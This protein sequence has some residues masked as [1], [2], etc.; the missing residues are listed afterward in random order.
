MAPAAILTSEYEQLWLKS[1]KDDSGYGL[2]EHQENIWLVI[3]P[4]VFFNQR[5]RLLNGRLVMGRIE[6]SSE[7]T[8]LPLALP[9][10]ENMGVSRLH[11]AIMPMEHGVVVEDVGSTNGSRINGLPLI[12]GRTYNLNHGDLLE[13][14]R[15][16]L[17]IHFVTM[18]LFLKAAREVVVRRFTPEVQELLVGL[19]APTEALIVLLNRLAEKPLEQLQVVAAFREQGEPIT[20]D[21]L[22]ERINKV[23][24]T[25]GG[26]GVLPANEGEMTWTFNATKIISDP[27]AT[28]LL[29]DSPITPQALRETA[30]DSKLI[31]EPPTKRMQRPSEQRSAAYHELFKQMHSEGVKIEAQF[32]AW[33]AQAQRLETNAEREMAI[34]TLMSMLIQLN[35]WLPMVKKDVPE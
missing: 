15:L 24:G 14:G 5:K 9:D 10:I 20:L 4:T 16:S 21:K 26:S 7:H 29:P 12:A 13:I 1:V 22:H 8:I 23:I 31:P 34:N 30:R 11:A 18:D 19:V 6:R 27:N 3:Q 28:A 17:N 35:T 33:M 2:F 25:G 32:Q